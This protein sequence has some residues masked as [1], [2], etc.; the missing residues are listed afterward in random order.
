MK[1]GI[2]A[3]KLTS[4]LIIT[5]IQSCVRYVKPLFYVTWIVRSLLDAKKSAI[6]IFNL[7]A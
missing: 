6:N 3:F 1:D 2:V 5:P 4:S 7:G